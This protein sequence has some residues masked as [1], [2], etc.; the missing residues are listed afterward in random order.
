M[1]LV[2]SSYLTT[3]LTYTTTFTIYAS[4]E[5]CSPNGFRVSSPSGKNLQYM[6]AVDDAGAIDTQNIWTVVGWGGKNLPS[7]GWFALDCQGY[8]VTGKGAVFGLRVSSG[9]FLIAGNPAVINGSYTGMKLGDIIVSE[10]QQSFREKKTRQ[11][12]IT[13][14]I[15]GY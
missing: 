5:P 10:A 13:M 2:C 12:L 15:F 8:L 4:S 3:S 9:N 11:L 14:Q 7:G 1:L 6:I